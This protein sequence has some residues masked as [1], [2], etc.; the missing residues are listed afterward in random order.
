MT[1][2]SAVRLD[3]HG[4]VAVLSLARPEAANAID[5]PSV[6][7]LEAV[8]DQLAKDGWAR[9]IV[10][11]ADGKIFCGGGDVKGFSSFLDAGPN[12]LTDHI[13]ELADAMHRMIEKLLALDAPLVAAVNG[14]A[15][16]AG[17][18]LVLAADLAYGGPRAKLSPAY[19]RIGLSADGGMTWT[20]PRIVGER[21]AAQI[22]LLNETLGVEEA[23]RLGLFTEA[24]GEEGE[25]FDAAVLAR[26]QK[27]AEGPR[28][29]QGVVRRLL[30]QSASTSLHDQ[31]AAEAEGIA[32]LAGGSDAREGLTAF[33][34]KRAPAFRQ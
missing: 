31:L 4:D 12:G 10:L 26:A 7:A 8:I 27:I 2:P 33:A 20:L 24:L 15:A 34:E 25:A 19:G 18:S 6:L 22:L 9:A 21:R 28:R 30:R 16:G 17:M 3:R 29:A 14:P 5:L 11:R 32:S 1:S 23:T 13:R